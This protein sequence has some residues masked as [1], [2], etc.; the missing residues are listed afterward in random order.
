MLENRGIF[1]RFSVSEN[2][3]IKVSSSYLQKCGILHFL[4]QD[5]SRMRVKLFDFFLFFFF[6]FFAMGDRVDPVVLECRVSMILSVYRGKLC[7]ESN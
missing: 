5:R 7:S 4:L 2:P 6:V 1:I 3:I